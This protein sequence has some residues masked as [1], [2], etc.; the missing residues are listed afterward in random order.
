M[1]SPPP[2]T[3]FS[4]IIVLE[5]LAF[6]VAMYITFVATPGPL[7]EGFRHLGTT[8]MTMFKLMLGLTDVEVLYDA[9]Q[10]WLAIA[11]F[12]LFVLLTYILML[13]ALIAMMSNTCSLVSENKVGSW[14]VGVRGKWVATLVSKD[15]IDWFSFKSLALEIKLK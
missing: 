10:P 7:P 3:R 5:L 11:L 9:A 14:G 1:L 13:N 4:T 15:T 2:L 8:C 6:S 12:V